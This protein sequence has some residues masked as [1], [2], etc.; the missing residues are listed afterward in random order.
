[1]LRIEFSP[2]VAARALAETVGVSLDVGYL[3]HVARLGTVRL[4]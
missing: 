3:V 2:R 1:V 4:R